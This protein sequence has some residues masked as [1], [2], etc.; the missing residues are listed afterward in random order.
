MNNIRINSNISNE[1]T[2][3]RIFPGKFP[4]DSRTIDMFEKIYYFIHK[5]NYEFLLNIES[6]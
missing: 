4:S 5:R 6:N 2:F 3:L 1:F